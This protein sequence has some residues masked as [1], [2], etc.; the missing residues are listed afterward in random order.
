MD[1]LLVLLRF[2]H[3]VAGVFWVGAGLCMTFFVAP[4]AAAAGA[5][6]GQFMQRL[7]QSKFNAAIA[8]SAILTVV[9]GFLLYWRL[10]YSL[11][12]ITGITLLA[13]GIVGLVALVHGAAITGP[14][15]AKLAKLSG[16]VQVSGK[17]PTADAMAQ[18]QKQLAEVRHAGLVSSTLVVIAVTAMAVARYL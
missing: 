6:G 5:A 4:A 3:I 18:L 8:L 15:T 13:G 14:A 9:G 2:V 1:I 17:P 11:A 7:G 10:G 16:E 12:S